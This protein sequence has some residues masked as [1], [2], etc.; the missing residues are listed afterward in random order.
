MQNALQVI[1]QAIDAQVLPDNKTHTHRF[2]IKSSSSDRL[3]VVAKSRSNG[4]W[5]CSCPGWIHARNGV[6]N[7]KHLKAILPALKALDAAESKAIGRRA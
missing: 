5:A 4:D 3:Y 6:R 7:C 2:E 1:A